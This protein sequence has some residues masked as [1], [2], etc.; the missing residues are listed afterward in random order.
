MA[1]CVDGLSKEEVWRNL[2]SFRRRLKT[3][4]VLRARCHL[5]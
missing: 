2:D 3:D 4:S 1:G 5:P